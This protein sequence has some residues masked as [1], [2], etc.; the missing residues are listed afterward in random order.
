MYHNSLTKPVTAA[1]VRVL[2]EMGLDPSSIRTSYD[3]YL[4]IRAHYAKW[5]RLPATAKQEWL[6]RQAG[7]WKDSM[8]RGAAADLIARIKQE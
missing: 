2:K 7:Q 6:L 4:L 1:Q 5:A 8:D 3:A